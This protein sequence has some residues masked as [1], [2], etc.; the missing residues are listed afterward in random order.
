MNRN[1]SPKSEFAAD[2][3]LVKGHHELLDIPALQIAIESALA[4]LHRRAA[5]HTDPTNFNACA[6]SHLRLLGAQDF[7]DTFLNLAEV[8]VAEKR[9]DST[10]LPGNVATLP[11]Q[12]N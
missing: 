6:A 11:R 1:P 3:L 10:N 7:V 4:E 5:Q 9:V 12:K 2:A 8:Q